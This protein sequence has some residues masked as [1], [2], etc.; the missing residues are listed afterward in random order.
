LAPALT[1]TPVF[2]KTGVA[3][4]TKVTLGQID[5]GHTYKFIIS[6]DNNPVET[7][8]LGYN[9]AQW[10]YINI[11]GIIPNA[12]NGRNIGIAEVDENSRVIRFS[13]G[14]AV[15]DEIVPD[16]MAPDLAV[17]LLFVDATGEGS[18]GK[19]QISLKN[20]DGTSAVDTFRY[21]IFQN[22]NSV[23]RPIT[24]FDASSWSVVKDND[25]ITA[26][27]GTHIGV[28]KVDT[29]NKVIQFSDATA[30]TSP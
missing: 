7:P 15:S 19:T 6:Q 9:A 12:E 11:G 23:S 25:I 13:N 26:N 29:A 17:V 22:V 27:H 28:S 4:N 20:A 24:G 18:D 3:G 2:S 21:F 14:I 8:P 1:V 30:V 16:V 10:N 5:A